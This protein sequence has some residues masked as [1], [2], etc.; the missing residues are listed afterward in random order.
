LP[1]HPLTN[2]P[3][4][5]FIKLFGTTARYHHRHEVFRDFIF[6][7]AAALS[8]QGGRFSQARED[9]YLQTINRY[10]PEDRAAF[11]QLFALLV[12]ALE[13][14]PRDVL[15]TIFMNLELGDAWRGQFF[16]PFEI[17]RMM[18]ELLFSPETEDQLAHGEPISVSEPA[19]GAGG[20]VLA[21]VEAVL[22]RGYNP[23]KVIRAHAIDVDRTAALMS[24]IQFS[25]WNVPAMVVVG[26]ALTLEEREVWDTPAAV[27]MLFGGGPVQPLTSGQRSVEVR[28]KDGP[29]ILKRA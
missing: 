12:Q 18:A 24:Y 15:G 13:P 19:V 23:A 3:I 6:C 11:Q 25:L 21:V 5:G 26:N 16:T 17:S 27:N 1:R 22:K 9:E 4:K 28:A 20:M 2:D 8:N 14:E 10:V 29:H 7:S